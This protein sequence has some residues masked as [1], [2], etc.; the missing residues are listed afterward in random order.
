MLHKWFQRCDLKHTVWVLPCNAAQRTYNRKNAG[1][2]NRTAWPGG[3]DFRSMDVLGTRSSANSTRNQPLNEL[4]LASTGL[5]RLMSWF[6]CSSPQ[7]SQQPL[8]SWPTGQVDN[9]ESV[10]TCAKLHTTRMPKI[11]GR[12]QAGWPHNTICATQ[13]S[14]GPTLSLQA[15]HHR[16]RQQGLA[17]QCAGVPLHIFAQVCCCTLYTKIQTL[18]STRP[19]TSQPTCGSHR[20]TAGAHRTE[21]LSRQ[22]LHRCV[23]C[24]H[25][26]GPIH[27]RRRSRRRLC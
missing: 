17:A 9:V 12:H 16:R 22:L 26:K 23:R 6:P 10:T 19:C 15:N 8:L 14:N 27:T 1:Q 18:Q 13:G 3:S 7:A 25:C 4:A 2:K 20:S 5:C 24:C 11:R 21:K